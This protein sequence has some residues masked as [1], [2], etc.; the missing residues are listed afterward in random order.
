MPI[1]SLPEGKKILRSLIAPGI[2][3]V[4]CCGACKFVACHCANGSSHIQ[5]IY[6]Y[7]SY[8][9]V[10]HADSFRINISIADMHR[11]TVR[12]LGVSNSF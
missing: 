6:F 7:Q 2:K 12:I 4:E 3:E 8:I 11:L 9:P 10:S 5:D 1:K